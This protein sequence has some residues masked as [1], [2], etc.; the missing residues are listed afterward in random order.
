MLNGWRVIDAQ[1]RMI[2]ATFSHEDLLEAVENEQFTAQEYSS[3]MV[4]LATGE[5]VECENDVMGNVILKPID[6]GAE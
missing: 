5:P 1:T 6:L 4:A 2:L 3:A